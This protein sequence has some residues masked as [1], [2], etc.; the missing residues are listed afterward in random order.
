MKTVGIRIRNMDYR[1]LLALLI[2]LFVLHSFGC[3]AQKLSRTL[4]ITGN[5]N[6]P[7]YKKEY[8]PWIHEFQNEK[9]IEILSEVSQ[10]DVATDLSVLQRDKLNQYD[11]IISNSIF[12]TPTEDQLNALYEFV[13][14]GKAYLTI[15]CGILSLLNWNRY[16]EFM[17]GIFIGGPSTVPEEFKVTTAN[18]EFWGYP[19]S[20]R[21]PLEHPI[22]A[23]V[24]DFVTRDELYYFQPSTPDFHVIARAENLPVMWWH[25]VGRGKVMSLTLGHDANAKA[26]PGYQALLK[27]GVQWLTRRPLLYGGHPR[28]VSTRN[29][30]Y[31]NFMQLKAVGDSD[32]SQKMK[33]EITG[34]SNPQIFTASCSPEGSVDLQLSG[35]EGN[36]IFSVTASTQNGLSSTR[37]YDITILPDGNGNIAS[38]YGNTAESSSS[39]ND[40]GMF[41]AGNVLDGDSTTRWSSGP[42]DS[43]WITIDLLKIYT[44]G[45]MTLEW[46]AS[47]A[48]RYSISGSKD[49]KNWKPVA[50]LSNGDGGTDTHN[51][52]PTSMRFIKITATERA[53][54]RW[55]Y[56]L[57]DVKVYK[58]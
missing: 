13:S 11:L 8:P 44:V 53:N 15:H 12:L 7:N 45:K 58:E 22:S 50:L 3:E 41:S 28:V 10:V 36:G 52:N 14:E 29:L 4:I 26:N 21:K 39:E 19:Y 55:G 49:G 43:A 48:K 6:V 1:N 5:G 51:F 32:V 47:F 54:K 16:E 56:S 24:D 33:F 40:S 46:E 23:V 25:P 35:R 20:F 38:Y 31:S 27:S 17:G 18:V 42:F 37:E 34:N 9:V 57:F 30:T 2:L